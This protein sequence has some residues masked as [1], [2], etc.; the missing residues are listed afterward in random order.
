MSLLLDSLSASRLAADTAVRDEDVATAFQ[1]ALFS[2]W[3]DGGVEAVDEALESAA[4]LSHLHGSGM[5]FLAQEASATNA[6]IRLLAILFM[7]NDEL[8]SVCRTEDWD[9]EAYADPLLLSVMADVHAKFLASEEKDGHLIDRHVWR[10]VTESGGK[11]ALYCTSFAVVIVEML[12]IVRDLRPDQFQRH[13]ESF[14]PMSCALIRVQ[15]E[16]MRQLVSEIL[17]RQVGPLIG[18]EPKA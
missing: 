12:K 3:G 4:R 2:D 15:S 8:S 6:I 16:E 7:R 5:F 9:R 18:V 1:E 14:F 10:N 17:T 11:V 13:K